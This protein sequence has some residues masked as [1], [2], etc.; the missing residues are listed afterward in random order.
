MTKING[1]NYTS[2][3][4]GYPNSYGHCLFRTIE[5]SNTIVWRSYGCNSKYPF[6]CQI[7]S[8]TVATLPIDYCNRNLLP[9]ISHAI[10]PSSFITSIG[11]VLTM[12]CE[13]GYIG[14][15][16]GLSDIQCTFGNITHGNWTIPKAT[17]LGKNKF[18]NII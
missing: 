14:S 10:L 5:V 1:S 3:G 11:S 17:C 2:W 4:V 13:S 7:P 16:Y 8:A 18:C 9:N 6:F 12:S 15:T